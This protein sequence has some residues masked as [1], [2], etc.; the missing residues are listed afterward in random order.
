[1][2]RS[3]DDLSL[4]EV[5]DIVNQDAEMR[6][7]LVDIARRQAGGASKG[8]R[9]NNKHDTARLRFVRD[10]VLKGLRLGMLVPEADLRMLRLPPQEALRQSG[11]ADWA[12]MEEWAER[13]GRDPRS[14][15]KDGPLDEQQQLTLLHWVSRNAARF[16][17]PSCA[18]RGAPSEYTLDFGL[19]AGK[20][21][22]ALVKH[23]NAHMTVHLLPTE[24]VDDPKPGPYVLW[25]ASADFDWQ[26]PRHV[27]LFHALRALDFAGAV[28]SDGMQRR[29]IILSLTA[30][31]C[32]LR[33]AR[34]LRAVAVRR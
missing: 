31:D 2:A 23:A 3:A 34:R 25:L 20:K 17:E 26:F 5:E 8:G 4:A 6:Q 27:K 33:R 29:A 7:I 14:Q 15:K 16:V 9:Y 24:N 13:H 11:G 21:L 32:A 22:L 1:M 28:V 19:Y 30:R 10:K 18:R 12:A